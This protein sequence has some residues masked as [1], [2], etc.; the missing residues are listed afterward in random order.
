MFKWDVVQWFERHSPGPENVVVPALITGIEST[1]NG[2]KNR[3][4]YA[5]RAYG[6]RAAFAVDRLVA[7]TKTNNWPVASSAAWAL[8]AI[9]PQAAIQAGI[10]W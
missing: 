7:F 4:A 10:N 3:C 5:L 9:D 8:K 2:T 1:D 6:P